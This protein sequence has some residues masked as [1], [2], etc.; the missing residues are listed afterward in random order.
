MPPPTSPLDRLPVETVTSIVGQLQFLDLQSATRSCRALRI[1]VHNHVLSI[2]V[3]TLRLWWPTRV[4]ELLI[5]METCGVAITG[6]P[7]ILVMVELGIDGAEEIYQTC[8]WERCTFLLPNDVLATVR[9]NLPFKIPAL[10]L[11][12]DLLIFLSNAITGVAEWCMMTPRGMRWRRWFTGSPGLTSITR[13]DLHDLRC[14]RMD[15]DRKGT[16]G[17]QEMQRRAPSRWKQL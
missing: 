5:I 1:A 12:S 9:A 3:R 16:T 2:V 15:I 17:L 13:G 14:A 4:E 10:I 11:D 8:L 7:A 6:T